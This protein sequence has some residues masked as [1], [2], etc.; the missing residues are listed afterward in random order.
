VRE[1]GIYKAYKEHCFSEHPFTQDEWEWYWNFHP[2]QFDTFK[3]GF[4][5]GIKSTEIDSL[6]SQLQT[7]KEIVKVLMDEL[8]YIRK[9][10]LDGF[11]ENYAFIR[12]RARNTLN[13]VKE[14]M[15]GKNE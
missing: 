4:E 1:S 2:A 5:A 13:K 10:D 7:Q 15:G 14:M 6:T 8:E 9:Y 12:G 3:A 11:P